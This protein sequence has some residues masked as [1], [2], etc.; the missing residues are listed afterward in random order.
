MNLYRQTAKIRPECSGY[1]ELQ[2]WIK[3]ESPT[4]SGFHFT[5]KSN[6]KSEEF[7]TSI[8]RISG[9]GPVS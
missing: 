6:E 4:Q 2:N 7:F 3:L 9:S 5:N 1:E 8:D